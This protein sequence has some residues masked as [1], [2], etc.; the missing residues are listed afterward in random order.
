MLKF[1]IK[2]MKNSKRK[3]LCCK[4]TYKKLGCYEKSRNVRL[5]S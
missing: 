2:R 4:K 5:C 1:D 3:V